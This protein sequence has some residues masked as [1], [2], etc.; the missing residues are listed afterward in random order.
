MTPLRPRQTA[1]APRPS[2]P[3]RGET[4]QDRGR[5]VYFAKGQT[6]A[7]QERW[8]MLAKL[9]HETDRKRVTSP[10]GVSMAALLA[11]GARSDAVRHARGAITE[12]GAPVPGGI[13]ALEEIAEEH[14]D[15][16]GVALVV[17][18]AQIECAWAYEGQVDPYALPAAPSAGF[19]DRFEAASALIVQAA[20]TAP[21]SAEIAATRCDLLAADPGAGARVDALHQSAIDADAAN[22]GRLRAYGVHLLPRWFGTH[23][24]LETTAQSVAAE[25]KSVWRDG[26]YTWMWF[27]ALRLDPSAA[28][29]LDTERF[30][31]GMHDIL[32]S[33]PDPVLANLFAAYADGMDPEVA[34]D[35]LS[36]S[37]QTARSRI[38]AALPELTDRHLTELHPQVWARADALPGA[39]HLG[40]LSSGRIAAAT[41]RA[42]GAVNSALSMGAIHQAN[43]TNARM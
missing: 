10:S 26:G 31:A 17:A 37:A 36:R 41:K 16:W 15:F 22:P 14:D 38:H 20:V 43:R 29:V 13:R 42:Q 11:D 40:P 34:P 7:R 23:D 12:G 25:M 30:I 32:T 35:D 8:D 18:R 33:R 5:N 1:T 6:L 4:A 28:S 27:D 21:L 24:R 3:V 39:S 2:L 9:I 19:L